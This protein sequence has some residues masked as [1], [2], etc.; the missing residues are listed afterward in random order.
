M[1]PKPDGRDLLVRLNDPLLEPLIRAETAEQRARELEHLIVD[2][3]GP[4]SRRILS[5]YTGEASLLQ[6]HEAD[7]I[8]ATIA[9]RLIAKLNGAIEQ[10]DRAVRRFEDYVATVT[11]NAV[12]DV[13][14]WRNPDRARLK[15]RLRHV[16]THDPRVAL[17]QTADGLACGPAGA[18]GTA[19]ARSEI[20]LADDRITPMMLNR[21]HPADAVA[22]L[23]GAAPEPVTFEALVRAMTDLWNITEPCALDV[24]ASLP[25]PAIA[26]FETRSFLRSVWREI[27]LLRPLQRKALLLNLRDGETVNVV[28]LVA[29]TGIASIDE[30]AETMD[31]SREE[32]AAI[33]DDLPL[34]DLRIAAMM[35]VTRQQVINLRK[36]ARER[37]ARRVMRR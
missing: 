35:Q 20:E 21:E 34:D 27:R 5:R 10:A 36:S 14:R 8:E 22:A 18:R 23:F 2:V 17:W 1:T 7:D 15:N 13:L 3:A 24:D 6:Q 31:L 9:L 32:L 37:L 30:I 33:W 29:L 19:A 11:Y 28:S 26:R 16:L 4:L 25:E 12:N